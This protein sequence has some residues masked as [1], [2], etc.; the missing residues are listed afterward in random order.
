VD[1]QTISVHLGHDRY[2]RPAVPYD[3]R[4]GH[5][6]PIRGVTPQVYGVGCQPFD[7]AHALDY[8]RQREL[9]PDGDYGRQR[10][11]QQ[12]LRAVLTAALH[13]GLGTDIGRLSQVVGAAGQALTLDTQGIGLDEWAFTLRHVSPGTL[14]TV[15]TNGGQLDNLTLNGIDY[16]RLNTDSLALLRSVGDDTIDRFLAVHPDWI[17]PGTS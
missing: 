4:T 6:V 14:V 9:L 16:Q 17:I 3:Q 12:F 13:R 15:R 5:P 11:Q 10:H 2:G 8:V 1:E 7:G